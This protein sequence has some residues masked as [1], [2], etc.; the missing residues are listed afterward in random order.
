MPKPSSLNKPSFFDKHTTDILGVSFGALS[1]VIFLSVAFL[2][3]D[4]TNLP[5]SNSTI[6]EN[7]HSVN[8]HSE[9]THSVNS[10]GEKNHGENNRRVNERD[11]NHHKSESPQPSEDLV[12]AAG[13]TLQKMP[14]QFVS[15]TCASLSRTNLTATIAPDN[16]MWRRT[17]DGWQDISM[18]VDPPP[19]NNYVL[20]GVHPAIWTAMLLLSSLL[21]LIMASS[22]H[23]VKKLL[24]QQSDQKG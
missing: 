23:D 5:P 24:G 4:A 9:N 20:E 16:T 21:L 8:G 1:I 6:G 10:H 13:P 19:A 14:L 15:D 7:S 2:W 22:N 17:T 12:A 18:A 11:R 3:F